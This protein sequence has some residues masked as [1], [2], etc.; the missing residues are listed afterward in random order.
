M[1]FNACSRSKVWSGKDKIEIDR[2]T[3]HI[4]NEEIDGRVAL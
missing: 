3:R 4:A 1:R 2:E